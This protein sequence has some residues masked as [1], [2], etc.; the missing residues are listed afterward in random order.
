MGHSFRKKPVRLS[1]Y[2][3][4]LP[5]EYDLRFSHWKRTRS[6]KFSNDYLNLSLDFLWGKRCV[7]GCW[8][9]P[10]QWQRLRRILLEEFITQTGVLTCFRYIHYSCSHRLHSRVA[11][12]FYFLFLHVSLSL[13]VFMGYTSALTWH[14]IKVK[15]KKDS[16]WKTISRTFLL[17]LWENVNFLLPLTASCSK[18]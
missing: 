17:A 15:K 14:I 11:Q 3:K 8:N 5:N 2:Y 12:A 13:E 18:N 9:G 4:V 1:D 16:T 6:L 10:F 7:Q